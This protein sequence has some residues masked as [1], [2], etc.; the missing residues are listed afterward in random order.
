MDAPI[1]IWHQGFIEMQTVPAYGPALERHLA[2]ILAPGT[3][4]ALHGLR[5]GTYAPH[6]TP[7]E[8]TRYAA[9]M[10]LHKQ[11]LLDNVRR[12][13]QE[14]FDAVAIAIL[15]NPALREAKTLVDIPVAGY[16]EAAM[17][18]ACL[19][20]D[21]FAVLAFNPDLL[22]LVQAQVAEYGLERHAGPLVEIE[23]DYAAVRRAFEEPGPLL[24]AFQVAARTAIAQGADVL[25]P[26]QT[27][28][29]EVLWQNGLFRVEDAPVLDALAAAVT[30]AETLARLRRASGLTVTRRG[31]FWR[32]PPAA[33]FEDALRQY[34]RLPGG[35][36]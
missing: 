4:V 18:L 31:Y 7:A 27:I 5:P 35:D 25:I 21:R 13:E 33:L 6:S 15:Q 32:R 34:R 23:V 12:A 28:L 9:V 2:A 36:A 20:G 19:L 16:G 3:T 26:G 17:H 14:G 22:A 29:A 1:R 30:T 11:Q 8:I 10:D 24:E